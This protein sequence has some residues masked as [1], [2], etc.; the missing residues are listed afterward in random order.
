L[1]YVHLPNL[2]TDALRDRGA[3]VFGYVLVWLEKELVALYLQEGRVVT[4]TVSPDGKA[5]VP[6][7]IAEAVAKV[8]LGAEYGAICFHEAPDEQLA[9]MYWSQVGQP[10]A[11]PA[12]LALHDGGAVTSYL[13]AQLFDG[14]LEVTVRGQ[15]S[16]TVFRDG[17]LK[18][19]FFAAPGDGTVDQ[20]LKGL[21]AAMRDPGSGSGTGTSG[22]L[23]LPR[24]RRFPVP[25]ALPV[26]A[27]PALIA[28]YRDLMRQLVDRL[29]AVGSAQAQHVAEQA[30]LHLVQQHP[31]L[32]HFALDGRA[33]RDPVVDPHV[34]SAT[35]A[36]WTTDVLWGAGAGGP[37]P[38]QL[39]A[40]LGR[41]RRHLLQSAGFW[42]ALP[43]R[44][45]W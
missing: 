37:P 29:A 32:H 43:W 13:M 23:A 44:V 6:V 36:K 26:Q 14:V 5:W 12:E 33:L 27:P 31:V 28:A 20:R 40:E 11:W 18:R 21:W 34:L 19:G 35:M 10:D 1:A 4:A 2:L 30:R 42:D 16:F 25:A 15:I 3:R 17:L 45:T 7:A 41:E 8:P 24:V 22:E 38:E 39:L 9:A